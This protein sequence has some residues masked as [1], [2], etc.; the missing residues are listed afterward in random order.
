MR[1]RK[2]FS[3]SISVT[4]LNPDSMSCL[5]F[6]CFFVVY[7]KRVGIELCVGGVLDVTRLLFLT[8]FS[9]TG[10]PRLLQKS[11]TPIRPF[12]LQV[13]RFTAS[14]RI[15]SDLTR[16]I[17]IPQLDVPFLLRS[18][19]SRPTPLQALQFSMV[20]GVSSDAKWHPKPSA[21]SPTHKT[22]FH[23]HGDKNCDSSKAKH[24]L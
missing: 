10:Y 6:V 3:P 17:L 7:L 24:P 8:A 12:T 19:G 11:Q 21:S 5:I 15:L 2:Y 13:S 18:Q 1:F 22:I 4:Y 9:Y 14:N 20:G 23:G 16:I